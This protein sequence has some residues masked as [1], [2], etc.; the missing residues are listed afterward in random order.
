MHLSRDEEG[1]DL[2]LVDLRIEQVIQQIRTQLEVLNN[3]LV[4]GD[5]HVVDEEELRELEVYIQKVEVE[6]LVNCFV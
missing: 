1:F 2:L 5:L 3:V 4:V 6:L